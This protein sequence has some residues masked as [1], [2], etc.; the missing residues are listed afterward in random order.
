MLNE[1]PIFYSNITRKNLQKNKDSKAHLSITANGLGLCF[2]AKL[3]SNFKRCPI[4]RVSY[5]LLFD[6]QHTLHHAK[7][8]WRASCNASLGKRKQI[9][10]EKTFT[11]LKRISLL[12]GT[13][14]VTQAATLNIKIEK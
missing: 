7:N 6:P 2:E 8:R 1:F 11:A 3:L 13:S 4:R 14:D 10:A 9:Q 12:N 5:E